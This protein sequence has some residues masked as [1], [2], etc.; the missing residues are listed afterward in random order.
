MKAAVLETAY[1]V[2]VTDLPDPEPEADQ[3]LVRVEACGVAG[4]DLLIFEGANPWAQ[5]ASEARRSSAA[6]VTLGHEFAGVVEAVGKSVPKKMVGRRVAVMPFHA[7]GKCDQCAARQPNRC[8]AITYLGHNTGWSRR[9]FYPGG[10][11]QRCA[12][13]ADAVRELPTRVSFENATFLDSLATALH[14]VNLADVKR[15]S[16]VL[17]IGCGPVGLCLAQLARKRGAGMVFVSDTYPLTL[18]VA[19]KVCPSATCVKAD[20]EDLTRRVRTDT[21]NTGAN[22]VFDTVG[23]P[24]TQRQARTLLAPGGT[25]INLAVTDHEFS[26]S[27]R[28]LSAER[29]MTSS[30]N[31]LPDE[32]TQAVKALADGVVKVAPYI[33]HRMGLSEFPRIIERLR[34]RKRH[35]ALKAVVFPQQD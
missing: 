8:R 27:L 12:V 23:I 34:V 26:M 13:W 19:A 32:F 25:I 7:C 11:A 15:H 6:N 9:R 30:L 17:V 29:A 2:V 14:A 24:E 10:M 22:Y 3:V 1:R 28:D 21:A 16:V 31:Y 35:N 33:T 5:E 18:D 20:T 4:T